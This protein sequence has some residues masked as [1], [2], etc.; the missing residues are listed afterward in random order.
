MT[1]INANIIRL[2]TGPS[3]HPEEV[4]VG[5]MILS[6]KDSLV[7]IANSIYETIPAEEGGLFGGARSQPMLLRFYSHAYK[8]ASPGGSDL[9]SIIMPNDAAFPVFRDLQVQ[10]L[11]FLYHVNAEKAYRRT[12]A[13]DEIQTLGSINIEIEPLNMGLSVFIPEELIPFDRTRLRSLGAAVSTAIGPQPPFPPRVIQT[14]TP[15]SN[16]GAVPLPVPGIPVVT[17]HG[18]VPIISYSGT[19]RRLPPTRGLPP[20]PSRSNY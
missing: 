16:I 18:T 8:Y 9:V 20:A 7:D 14:R 15:I 17:Q 6:P 1:P 2:E 5:R 19:A 10:D 12:I 4:T 11:G 3:M 13:D